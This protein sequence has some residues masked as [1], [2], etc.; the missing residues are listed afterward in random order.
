MTED[1]IVIASLRRSRISGISMELGQLVKTLSE[2]PIDYLHVSL[3]D[4]HSETE[5]VN[6]KGNCV[7]LLLDWINGRYH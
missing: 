6:I 2:K 4:I 3:M 7:K 5:K 1:F